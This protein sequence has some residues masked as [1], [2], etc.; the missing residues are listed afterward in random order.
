MEL[1][2]DELLEDT[3]LAAIQYK[4]EDDFIRMLQLEMKR[5]QISKAA[6]SNVV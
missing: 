2:S 4:L 6:A 1:L 5:R 3:Y